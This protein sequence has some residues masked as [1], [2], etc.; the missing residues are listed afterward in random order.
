MHLMQ[1][2]QKQLDRWGSLSENLKLKRNE[3][4]T[5]DTL[6]RDYETEKNTGA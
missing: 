3:T 4:C 1:E 5:M 6:E 2:S